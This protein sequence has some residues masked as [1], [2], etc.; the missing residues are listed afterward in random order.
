MLFF[1]CN[2]TPTTEIYT[3]LL[4]L[5]LHDAL[6]ISD[7]PGRGLATGRVEASRRSEAGR[8]GAGPPRRAPDALWRAA[9]RPGPAD[10]LDNPD[11]RVLAEP[12]RRPRRP[13]EKDGSMN[14]TS[15]ETR[16]VIVEREIPHP[17]EK[18]WRALTE[19]HLIEEWLMKSDFRPVVG[20]RFNLRGDWGGVLDCEVL[21]VEDRKSVV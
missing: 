5:A 16:S 1:F 13:A 11:D 3:Y 2:S 15:T 9:R 19:P 18:L 17:P 14:V 4:T 10:R 6:P 20:H 21:E 7:G 12:V 8:A